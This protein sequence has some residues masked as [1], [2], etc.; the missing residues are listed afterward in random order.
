MQEVQL[1]T[2]GACSGNPGPGGYGTVLVFGGHR[3][4]ISAGFAK[5]TNN[6]MEILA[7]I[8]GLEALKRPCKVHVISDSKYVVDSMNGN[9]PLKWKARAWK[10]A[11]GGMVENI[12][13]WER[14]IS[15]AKTHEFTFEWVKGHAGHAEN[16]TCDQLA[17]TASQGKDLPPD[18][19]YQ[20]AQARR[21]TQ[22]DLFG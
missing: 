12:D 21:N 1:Y 5:T 17:V 15:L 19:G 13:L 9:W 20:E 7:V 18:T 14:M 8:A 6:R 22:P 16:E 4:E 2:D 3:R 11:R 10:K